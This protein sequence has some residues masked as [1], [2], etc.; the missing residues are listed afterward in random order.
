MIMSKHTN[1]GEMIPKTKQVER[2][3][4]MMAKE[5]R[6]LTT[7]VSSIFIV[8][9]ESSNSPLSFLFASYNLNQI[10]QSL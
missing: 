6:N 8:F 9:F 10:E 1:L 2:W 4:R 3:K 5:R 7:F